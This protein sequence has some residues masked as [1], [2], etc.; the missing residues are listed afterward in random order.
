MNMKSLSITVLLSVISVGAM[1]A[2]MTPEQMAK[3][4]SLHCMTSPTY[5][6]SYPLQPWCGCIPADK[7]EIDY[8]QKLSEAKDKAAYIEKNATNTGFNFGYMATTLAKAQTQC[9]D[10]VKAGYEDTELSK[11]AQD[12]QRTLDKIYQ[13]R[14]SAQAD[15]CANA[16]KNF[17]HPQSNT[18]TNTKVEHAFG[19]NQ[20]KHH[21]KRNVTEKVQSCVNNFTAI[22]SSSGPV[23]KVQLYIK[24]SK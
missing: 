17:A 10:T 19:D 21:K 23:E 11:H 20:A 12:K 13:E 3:A 15:E 9:R 4:Q 2:T 18:G 24:E 7:A 14:L 1:A 22:F 8:L 5:Q 6:P 16:Q